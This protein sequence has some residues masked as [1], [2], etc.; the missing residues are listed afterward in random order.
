LVESKVRSYSR[1]F[2]TTFKHAKNAEVWDTDGNRYIDF[3]SGCGSLNFGHNNPVFKD[4]LMSYI[5]ND[6]IS[7]GLDMQTEVTSSFSPTAFMG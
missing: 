5:E 3:L 6:G 1:A 7:L 2:P 4:V